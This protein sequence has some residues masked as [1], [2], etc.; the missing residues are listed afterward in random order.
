MQHI[1][2]LSPS[3]RRS[4]KCNSNSSSTNFSAGV[5]AGYWPTA[6]A[7]GLTDVR[8]GVRVV[9]DQ[10]PGAGVCAVGTW[11]FSAYGPGLLLGCDSAAAVRSR[12]FRS[13]IV[14][15]VVWLRLTILIIQKFIFL[16]TWT[17]IWTKFFFFEKQN[18]H[19]QVVCLVYARTP[20]NSTTAS[21]YYAFM[22]EK[23]D[24]TSDHDYQYLLTMLSLDAWFRGAFI[25]QANC[26]L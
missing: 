7:L 23:L 11:M 14:A 12:N 19:G 1:D 3:L 25:Q 24:L 21:L 4:L 15:S 6:A 8:S 9:W 22:N 20:Y 5:T 18:D 10:T 17:L 26:I 16:F 13:I 2:S